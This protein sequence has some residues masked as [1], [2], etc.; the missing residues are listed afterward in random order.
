MSVALRGGLE[1]LSGVHQVWLTGFCPGAELSCAKVVREQLFHAE[2]PALSPP[3]FI[4]P[5]HPAMEASSDTSSMPW[6]KLG[7]LE[8]GLGQDVPGA[9]PKQGIAVSLGCSLLVA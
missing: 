3:R 1:P 7:G 6:R 9:F 2:G 8:A 4:V 5:L